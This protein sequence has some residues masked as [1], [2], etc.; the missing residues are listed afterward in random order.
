[1]T[2]EERRQLAIDVG[3]CI[4]QYR[5][6]KNDYVQKHLICDTI[7]GPIIDHR[8]D[9]RGFCGPYNSKP[10]FLDDLTEDFENIGAETPLSYLYKKEHRSVLLTQTCIY[11]TCLFSVD[12]SAVSSIGKMSGSNP[13]FGN[14]RGLCGGIRVTIGFRAGF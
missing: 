1:M 4:S 11:R 13:S 9:D 7:G 12:H 10:E 5:Q 14:T 2:Y 6:I 8:T 3:S